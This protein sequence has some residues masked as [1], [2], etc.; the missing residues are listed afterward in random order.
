[1]AV[2][3][4]AAGLAGC[5]AGRNETLLR[6]RTD[7]PRVQ[8]AAIAE[9][10]RAKDLSMAGEL[11]N[12]LE[13]QDEGVRFMAAAGLHKL[14]G[15][16]PGFHFADAEKRQAIVAEWR[17][18]WAKESAANGWDK[19]PKTAAETSKAENAKT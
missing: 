7:N 14:T 1:M 19:N 9:V 12:L 5:A 15:R 4:L 10:V 8:A 2:L 13:S 3:V 17:A 18:W 6:L 16:D 11:V